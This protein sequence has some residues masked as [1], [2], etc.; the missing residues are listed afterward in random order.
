MSQMKSNAWTGDPGVAAYTEDY[1]VSPNLQLKIGM[2]L[3]SIRV[4]EI[5]IESCSR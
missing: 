1:E 4:R 5:M 2:P 3:S